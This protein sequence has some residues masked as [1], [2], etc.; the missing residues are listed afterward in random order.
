M[1]IDGNAE[2]L[3]PPYWALDVTCGKGTH[4]SYG[5]WADRQRY[6]I[7]LSQVDTCTLLSKITVLRVPPLPSSCIV[8]PGV[9]THAATTQHWWCCAPTL[10][11]ILHGYSCKRGTHI[12]RLQH[13]NSLKDK[14][15]KV[16]KQGSNSFVSY[17]F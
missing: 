7:T 4:L 2:D 15:V 3:P 6:H 9:T 13:E 14:A 16:Q 11:E 5:P 10:M 8:P 12:T 17:C 1:G